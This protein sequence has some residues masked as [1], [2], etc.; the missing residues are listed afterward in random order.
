MDKATPRRSTGS[1][2]LVPVDHRRHQ[3]WQQLHSVQLSSVSLAIAKAMQTTI[4]GAIIT[5]TL[6]QAQQR[7]NRPQNRRQSVDSFSS[8]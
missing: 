8:A 4:T 6:G 3:H 2:G 7:S 1:F 5:P